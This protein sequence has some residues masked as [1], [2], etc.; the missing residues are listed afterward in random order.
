LP[1]DWDGYYSDPANLDRIPDPLL[2]QVGEILSP[3]LALDV[4]CGPGRHAIYLKGLGWRVTAVDSSNNAI[5]HL[6]GTC[7]EVEAILADLECGEYSITP[8]S[9]DLVCDFYYLQRDLFPALKAAVRAGGIFVGAIHLREP[10]RSPRYSLP[11]GQLREEFA[12]WKISYYSEAGETG[13]TRRSARI[14][15]RKA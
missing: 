13:R 7:P 3:G 5:A 15:A 1:R 14:I 12:G 2:V 9:F 10:G 11:P 6:R 4:A 8:D